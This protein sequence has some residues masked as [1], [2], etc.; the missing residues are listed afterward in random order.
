MPD[1]AFVDQVPELIRDYSRLSRAEESL[2]LKLAD[3][4]L[5]QT[6]VA[7][8]VGCSQGTVSNVLAAFADTRHIARRMLN[9]SAADISERLTKTKHAPT[10]LEVLRDLEVTTK[11]APAGQGKG[12]LT[13]LIGA[14]DS[15]VQV[16]IL[17]GPDSA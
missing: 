13:V 4:G 6:Q 5:T 10:M 8:R 16:N 3:D 1:A 2:I 17:T 7:Q 9:A 12:G 11:Q 15:Q 14:Q